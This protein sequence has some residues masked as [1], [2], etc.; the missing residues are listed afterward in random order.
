LAAWTGALKIAHDD[1]EREGV[2]IHLARINLK[3]GHYNESRR[4]LD[5]V[6]NSTYAVLKSR[7]SRNLNAA[8]GKPATNAPAP[9][10]PAK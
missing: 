1:V 10:A 8:L 6:T 4:W 9:A 2:Y 3:L 5:A 7:I